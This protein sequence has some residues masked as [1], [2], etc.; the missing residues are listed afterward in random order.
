MKRTVLN[1]LLF[2]AFLPLEAYND[3]RGHNLDSL[4]RAVARWTPDAVDRASEQELLELNRAYRDLMLGYAVI[5]GEKCIFYGRKALSISRPRGWEEANA[6]AYRNI[7]QQYYGREQY[8]SAM[9]YYQAALASVEKMAS[10][11]TSPLRPEGYSQLDVDNARSALYGTIGNL[12][13]MMGDVPQA[14][15]WYAK[16]GEIF[17]QYGWN[18][19]NSVLHYNMGETWVDEGELKKARKEYDRA[20]EYAQAS[21]D[22][23]IMVE[24]WKGY[25][26]LYMEQ[27][28]TWKSLPYLRKADAY[29]AAHPDYAPTFRT[30][31]L[32]Y[33]KEVLGRQKSQLGILAGALV[34][35]ALIA[36]GVVVGRKKGK[37]EKETSSIEPAPVAATAPELTSRDKE[38]LDLL[39]KGYTATQIAEA[40]SL[41]P[42]TIRWYRKRLLEKFDVANTPELIFQARELGVI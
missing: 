2:L 30:E 4:E 39:A 41:S 12:Y 22:S 18:E 35:L 9:V 29:Y 40:L 34:A 24:V 37:E 8:D 10:G 32:D 3:H 17:E 38:I 15:E 23:L 33:M 42:E 1:F 27:G 31:N 20:M 16:A 7:G 19:S 26:R 13:N 36:A 25:G 21:G 5:N 28:R 6:D 14:M 11:A